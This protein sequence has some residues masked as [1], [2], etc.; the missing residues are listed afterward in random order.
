MTT[1]SSIQR[2]VPLIDALSQSITE[3]AAILREDAQTAAPEDMPQTQS[4]QTE[5][6]T[7][8]PKK[9]SA[10]KK[11]RA[12]A[13]DSSAGSSGV[14]KK[15]YTI[16]QVRAILAEKSQA[17]FTAQVKELLQSFG[18]VKLSGIDQSRYSELIEAAKALQ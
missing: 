9:Q 18:S 7:S 1:T 14:D 17:G 11:E 3:I 15:V 16:E 12:V 8:S 4:P 5:E 10:K 6:A 13:A 2:L